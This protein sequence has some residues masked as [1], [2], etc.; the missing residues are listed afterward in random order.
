MEFFRFRNLRKPA[1]CSAMLLLLSAA[2]CAC[3]HERI[4]TPE[5]NMTARTGIQ[6]EFDAFC[7]EIFREEL[8]DADTLSLHYTLLNPETCG[9]EP[10]EVSLGTCSFVDMV[11]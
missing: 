10:A 5:E 8:A 4:R 6:K 3:G 9:I 11:K 1:V 7:N 2:L